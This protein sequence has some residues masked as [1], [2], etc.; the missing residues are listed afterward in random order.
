M[1]AARPHSFCA[2]IEH[3]LCAKASAVL[4]SSKSPIDAC[5]A[6]G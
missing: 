4:S 6:L 2:W 3:P 5:K 1:R